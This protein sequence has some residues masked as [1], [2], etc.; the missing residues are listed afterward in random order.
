MFCF[1]VSFSL[2]CTYIFWQARVSCPLLCLCRPFMSFEGWLNSS[3]ENCRSKRTRYQLSHPYH[4]LSHPSPHLATYPPTFTLELFAFCSERREG[5]FP[6]DMSEVFVL[7]KGL[8][9]PSLLFLAGV[10]QI[11][12]GSFYCN[13]A[14][15]G[16][17]D[18]Y[19][20]REV[21]GTASK[22]VKKFWKDMNLAVCPLPVSQRQ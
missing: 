8:I 13:L 12:S 21:I 22:V 20:I 1:N 11:N 9:P 7:G 2:F 3:S 14:E 19:K 5:N 10:H 15:R 18:C 6:V 4:Q 16:G 17:R